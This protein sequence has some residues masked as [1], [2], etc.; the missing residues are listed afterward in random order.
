MKVIWTREALA[1]LADIA[2]YY[3]TN[4][5]PSIAEA[6]GRRFVDVV[7]RIRSV[8]LS[9]PRV[10]HR[11][12]IRVAAVVRYPFRIFYRVRGDVIHIL[13]IRHTSRQPLTGL[14]EPPQ[15]AMVDR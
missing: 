2:T 7:E 6:V 10:R 4:A 5:S 14:N 8:P 13:H 12:Q 15:P 1:D 9:A 11:S 3:T